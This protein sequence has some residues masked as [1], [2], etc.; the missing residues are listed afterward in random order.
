MDSIVNDSYPFIISLIIS[1]NK[2]VKKKGIVP[3]TYPYTNKSLVCGK[4]IM[5]CLFW[6]I[7]MTVQ[8]QRKEIQRI[9]E[10]EFGGVRDIF[11]YA[12]SSSFCLLFVVSRC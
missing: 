6:R 11:R 10:R 4:V 5:T 2:Q 7:Y 3:E 12:E 1:N 8:M 9:K